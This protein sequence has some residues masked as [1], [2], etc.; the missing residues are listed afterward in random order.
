MEAEEV[1]F[2]PTISRRSGPRSSRGVGETK[3]EQ[4]V[5][6]TDAGQREEIITMARELT[7]ESLN[8]FRYA[9]KR[10]TLIKLLKTLVDLLIIIGGIV[11]GVASFITDECMCPRNIVTGIAGV[12]ISSLKTASV[13]FALETRG[14]VLKQVSTK[15]RSLARKARFLVSESGDITNLRNRL[16]KLYACLDD[17]DILLYGGREEN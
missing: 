14:A 5:N 6:S 2:L 15:L 9:N 10:A 16:E 3:L 7:G 11:V 4:P 1:Y 8:K 13:V 12:L 17:C